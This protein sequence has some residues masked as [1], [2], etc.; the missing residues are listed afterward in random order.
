M[1][2]FIF[3]LIISISSLLAQGRIIIPHPPRL[4][5]PVE[6]KPVVLEK[7]IARIKL[8]G[9]VA[10]VQLNQWFRNPASYRQEGAY[11]YSFNSSARMDAFYLYINGRKVAGQVLDKA[12]AEK[13]YTDIV[14]R[15]KDP[16][17][18]E[19]AGYG[20][21]KTRIF[22]I[23]ANKERQIELHYTQVTT[24]ENGN[25]K[26][27]LPIRQSGQGRIKS[28]EI[29]I[30]LQ[31]QRPIAT[32]YSPSHKIEVR[33]L[34]ANHFT[35]RFSGDNMEGMQ[36]FVMYYSLQEGTLPYA[37]FPF[38]PRTD[39]YG[40]FTIFVAPPVIAG[41][42][43]VLPKDVIF[44]MDASGSM[45][46]K[47]I[48]QARSALKYCIN[49]L[50]PQ[51]RF[52]ILRFSSSVSG[53]AGRLV[54]V[55]AD[56]RNNAGYFIDNIRAAGGTNIDEALRRALNLK[57]HKDDRL[58]SIVFLTD[59]LPTEGEKNIQTIVG[60][61]L[62][63]NRAEIRFFN[64]GV[65]YDVN[66]FLLDKLALKTRGS[67]TYVRP[68]EDIEAPVSNLFAKISSPLLTHVR[69]AFT[70]V[71]TEDIFPRKLPELFRGQRLMISGRYRQ[72]G[73]AV[74][75]LRGEQ[76]GLEKV[77][78]IPVEFPRRELSNEFVARLWANRKVDYYLDKIRFEGERQEWV[79]TVKEL[80]GK[81]GIITPYTS[82]LVQAQERELA[83]VQEQAGATAYK[84]SEQSRARKSSGSITSDMLEA[85]GSVSAIPS[86]ASGA[87]AVMGS[88]S[89]NRLMKTNEQSVQML[90]IHKNIAGRSFLLK[91]GVWMEDGS[92]AQKASVVH[93]LD[94][95]Y[96]KLVA[97]GPIVRRIL[98]LGPKVVFFY[99]GKV[100]RVE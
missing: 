76:D 12:A 87:M 82:Y 14:R 89:R 86:R 46:G 95:A 7:S 53:F 68:S 41:K 17:L 92:Q 77:F 49:V 25:Y 22:P 11:L 45:G 19:Y 66:T 4:P 1:R 33:R 39:R 78:K 97:S 98:A 57:K 20:A 91:K 2:S 5:M 70:G 44:V 100:F 37:F 38:R 21:F 29:E 18:L 52:E 34:K 61:A 88:R 30:D 16:A 72:G 32:V 74:V 90:I 96:M 71:A 62:D 59:G 83:D 85:L 8:N 99:D 63:K 13:I 9:D 54:A 24:Y 40:F 58:T 55:N 94:D 26:F 28:Y 64:F 43:T 42:R 51:D 31:T 67:T 6:I 27:S 15:M 47:K 73:K 69:L 56:S 36:D 93:M 84:M 10:R 79:A 50:N 23:D 48:A 75:E 35:I 80:A 3:I 65:G 60:H 81:Y